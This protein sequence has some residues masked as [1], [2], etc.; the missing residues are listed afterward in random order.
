VFEINGDEQRRRVLREC[1]VHS[2]T[3]YV[4]LFNFEGGKCTHDAQSGTILPFIR[5]SVVIM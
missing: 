2:S 5:A 1:R 3:M 4:R